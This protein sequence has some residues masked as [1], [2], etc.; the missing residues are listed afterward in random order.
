MKQNFLTQLPW[1]RRGKKYLVIEI[2]REYTRCTPYRIHSAEN[3]IVCGTPVMRSYSD[4]RTSTVIDAVSELCRNVNKMGE[5][6]II[7]SLDPMF[8][9]TIHAPVVL[10]RE[11]SSIPVDVSDLD[12]RIGQGIWKVFDRERSRAALKMSVNDLEVLPTDVRI[13][14][15]RLDGHKVINPVG[16]HAQEIGM[17]VSQT[18]MPR[19]FAAELRHIIPGNAVRL[20]GEN[21]VMEAEAIRRVVAP[22]SF[23]F[24][25]VLDRNTITTFTNEHGTVSVGSFPW[26]KNDVVRTIGEVFSVSGSVA[27]EILHRYNTNRMS[28]P[29]ALR[30]SKV[31]EMAFAGLFEAMRAAYLTHSVPNIYLSINLAVPD[32]ILSRKFT[33]LINPRL[34]V[35][36]IDAH[37]VAQKL[38]L[39]IEPLGHRLDLG[40]FAPLVDFYF[41]HSDDTM[42]RIARRHARW[43]VH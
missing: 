7:V 40:T 29:V 14:E 34:S 28:K 25:R 5:Y 11:D 35:T 10:A 12:N 41:S 2:M 9:T 26:G 18:F 23:L 3:K 39:T 30:F 8:A 27:E 21:A 6:E 19:L 38:G 22:S 15:V 33:E 20:M 36:L 4:A 13:K 1:M 32:I 31:V 37:H 17:H 42:S 16:F 43:L 24:L